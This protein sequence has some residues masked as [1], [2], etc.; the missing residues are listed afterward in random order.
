MPIEEPPRAG[1]TKSGQPCSPAKSTI[2]LRAAEGSFS[3][4]R[5]RMTSYGPTG[6]PKERNT[7]F[8]YSLSWPTAEASTPEP[9]YGTPESSRRPWRVP[10]S[11]YGP[12]SMG[13]T[14]STSPSA[15]G[16]EPGSL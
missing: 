14:T 10:S 5:G 9:T 6:S 2:F 4:S 1:F 7:R 8:M 3:H 15:L 13:K 16:T 11:P 12:C